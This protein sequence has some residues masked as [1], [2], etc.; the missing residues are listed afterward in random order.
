MYNPDECRAVEV[1]LVVNLKYV[2]LHYSLHT[3]LHV[4]VRKSFP[5]SAALLTQLT[6]SSIGPTRVLFICKCVLC[7]VGVSMYMIA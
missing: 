5:L 1:V 7:V 6:I 4:A 2:T 3:A